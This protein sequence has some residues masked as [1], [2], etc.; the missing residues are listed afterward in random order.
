MALKAR[1]T[2][3]H[4]VNNM[5]K[6]YD[7]ATDLITF[8]RGSSAT[9]TG[10]DG[11]QQTAASD[12]P[13]IEYA[14]DGTLKGLLIEEQR[15]NLLLNSDN[16][17]T[18]VA[19]LAAGSHTLSFVG[20][21]SVTGI[22]DTIDDNAVD[23]FVYDTSKDSDGGAW[24]TGSLAQASSWYAEASSPTRDPNTRS[25][26]AEFPAVAVIVAEA[27]KVTIYDGD[28]PSLPMWMV[29]TRTN[30]EALSFD[31]ITGSQPPISS[32]TAENALLVVG[33]NSFGNAQGVR[34]INFLSETVDRIS[35][36]ARQNTWRFLGN[37]EQRND[38]LGGYSYSSSNIVNL[39][40]ND[41]AMTVLPDAPT[42]S[43][44][45]LPVPTIAV[46]TDGG[47]SVIKDD[48][49]VWD[50]FNT[51][52]SLA[53]S[54]L[55]S[56]DLLYQM[57]S[58]A[59][60]YRTIDV[61]GISSDGFLHDRIYQRRV[62]AAFNGKYPGIGVSNSGTE[63]AYLA[64][65]FALGDDA[66]GL[67]LIN[68]GTVV[69]D[70]QNKD[71]AARVTST[72]TTGW[73]PGDIK[74]AAL[75][76]TTAETFGDA[77]SGATVSDP[78]GDGV[79][80]GEHVT[81]GD[82]ATDSD[83][84]KGTGWTINTTTGVASHAPGASSNIT[85]TLSLSPGATYVVTYDITAVTAGTVRAQFG[86]TVL[87]TSNGSIGSYSETF[88]APSGS[89]VLTIGGGA[90]F[91]GSI[92]NISVRLA[93]PDRSVNGNGLAVHGSITK[94]PVATGADL[95]AYSGFSA[96]NYLEQPY[97]PDLD[98]A[99]GDFCV[100]GWFKENSLDPL[101][102]LL[103]RDTASTAQ[104]FN[105]Y[106]QSGQ[107]TFKLDD[108]TS[109]YLVQVAGAST[110]GQWQHFVGVKD[111]D[112]AYVY[113]NGV[114]E[115]SLDVSAMGSLT[116]TSAILRLGRAANST[117]PLSNGSLA[118]WRI[119]ATA[120]TADQIAKIYNDERPLFQDSAK[121]TL[122]GSSDAVTALAHDPDTNLLHVGTS[123]GRSVF[124]GLRRVNE[125]AT[126]V[127]TAISAVDGLI[128]E[129]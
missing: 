43:A 31:Q 74:L 41:V 20:G 27:S 53:V 36:A 49:N 55:G 44:T 48:G 127:T 32:L 128:V 62:D 106:L 33:Q 91:D 61:T 94:A 84:T 10:S 118:L 110:A 120:P 73:M 60:P 63:F 7:N 9:Y 1:S 58:T 76:D 113:I 122:T 96:S 46:A 99:D 71:L 125:T 39:A 70:M 37:I 107:L 18:Q 85:Q 119:S 25:T 30:N 87:G 105:V 101:A 67:D 86:G 77:V 112:T 111:G 81:N 19:S 69:A 57:G 79:Y 54:F 42:D 59:Q 23:V 64:S 6:V 104:N 8:A 22:S 4:G 126:A 97:N 98:F 21:P 47:V 103:S 78:N 15:T 11:T 2:T 115:A 95:V 102:Y 29:F 129:Q 35:D 123:G 116:N 80:D 93:N 100:M 82:F 40:V 83:W 88:T 5:A 121:A 124:Y 3:F 72:Y 50:S 68:L 51:G 34:L 13:R 114:S 56:S 66:E 108:D 75:A 90:A 117:S 26:R 92:D 109:N 45:G 28:D 89:V 12:E 17:N 38:N 52:V 16:P 14:A 24:R 65:G